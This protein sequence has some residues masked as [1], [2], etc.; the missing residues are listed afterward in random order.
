MRH[1]LRVQN[2]LSVTTVTMS[3]QMP[4][5]MFLFVCTVYLLTPVNISQVSIQMDLF[6]LPDS[7]GS[8]SVV[9]NFSTYMPL[10]FKGSV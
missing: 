7:S 10:F 5:V 3:R 9:S 6:L 1:A 4:F 8:H 2:I